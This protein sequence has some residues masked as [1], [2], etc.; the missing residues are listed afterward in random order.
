MTTEQKARKRIKELS[1]EINAYIKAIDYH[2][3]AKVIIEEELEKA[4]EEMIKFINLIDPFKTLDKH[5]AKEYK[6][7]IN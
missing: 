7:K 4:Q 6:N 5:I 1:K 2:K 3:S